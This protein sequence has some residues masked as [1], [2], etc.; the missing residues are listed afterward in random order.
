ML[1]AWKRKE[2]LQLLDLYFENKNLWDTK[3]SDYKKRDKRIISLEKITTALKVFS[4]DITFE[5][6]SNKIHSLRSQYSKEKAKNV[7]VI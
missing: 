6:V 1:R 7:S 2:L 5:D 4:P 3:S